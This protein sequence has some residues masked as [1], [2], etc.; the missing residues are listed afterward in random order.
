MSDEEIRLEKVEVK[1]QP[2]SPDLSGWTVEEAPAVS[3]IGSSV[4]EMWAPEYYE[5]VFKIIGHDCWFTGKEGD[6]PT[7]VATGDPFDD[8]EYWT[9]HEIPEE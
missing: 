8:P 3:V 4:Y 1:K 7:V 2:N 9:I 5:K 6:G